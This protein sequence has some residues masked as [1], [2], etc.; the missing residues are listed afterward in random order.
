MRL[1]FLMTNC[2]IAAIVFG[3]NPTINS[4][5][6]SI[7]L[8]EV[9]VT[10]FHT[11]T[12]WKAMPAAIAVITNKDIARYAG[13]S[14]VPVLN[15]LPGIRMEERSPASYRLS[16][17]GSLLRSPFGVRNVKV[18]WNDLPLTDG[19][20]NTYLN[21]VD[22]GQLSGAEVLKGPAA[23]VYGAGTGG[24]L[25][26]KSDQ[27]FT[28]SGTHQYELGLSG[29]SYGLLQQQAGWQYSNQS[30]A[31]SFHQSHQQADGYRQQSAMRKDAVAW[32]GTLQ[33]KR[34]QLR[35]LAFYTDLYYQTPGGITLAQLQQ[36]PKLARQPSGALPGAVQQQ[37]AIY[38]KTG[39][40]GIYH[41]AVLSGSFDLESFVTGNI[42]RFENP[43]ITNYEK[44]AEENI[45]GGTHLVFHKDKE[46]YALRWMTGAEWI[47][48]HSNI[49]DFSNRAGKPDT[50]QFRDNIYAAQ[51]FVF[52][53]MEYKVAAKWNF[54]AG[55]SINNQSYRFRRLTDPS[56]VYMHTNNG[57]VATP[58]FAVLY[59]LN[60]QVS[61]YALAAKGFSPP[62]LA[63]LRPA[64]RTYHGEL[65]A[66]Q[67]W[68]YEVGIKGIIVDQR[69]QFDIAAY[70]FQ[71]KDA[72][73][74]RSNAQGAEYFVNAGGTTQKGLEAL[75]KYQLLKKTTRSITTVNLWSSY[76]YQPYYFDT[77]KQGAVDYSGNR[78]TGVPQNSWLNGADLVMRN[79]I[80]ANVSLNCT[81]S[82]P[83]TDANDA[84]ADAYQL[85]QFKLGYQWKTAGR[86]IH[87]FAGVD[88]ALNQVYSLGNDINAVGKRYYNPATGRNCFAGIHFQFR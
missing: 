66:E 71:L 69:L 76:S 30:F 46:H 63:E 84:N 74:R 31:S 54:T 10:A 11:T 26:L 5:D 27:P 35:F 59:R 8:N 56:S 81:S 80:Y 21:L 22:L 78:L 29:G 75:V 1:F 34:Q 3:Q 32:R 14:L 20:G 70:Y 2:L 57:T 68:N 23:S 65:Q 55:I 37:T 83:L 72:I 16:V 88:N 36:D 17:R 87:F 4:N 82:L 6:S 38:N 9:T 49:Q 12:Q 79:G 73:V 18:Y 53:Q 86:T 61:V 44:R 60:K 85:L 24:V 13:T 52:S 62:S 67:G 39:F 58:R 51:W 7:V 50:V 42:T 41:E 28:R 19:G 33:L 43:F 45:S 64:D 48:N 47:Y 77:Y 15:A 25:L 40:A